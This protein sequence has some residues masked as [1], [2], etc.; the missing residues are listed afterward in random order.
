MRKL[1][2]LLAFVAVVTNANAQ[3]KVKVSGSKPKVGNLIHG[4][5]TD[6]IGPMES[7][8]IIE[9]DTINQKI[10][11]ETLT[12]KNG[13]FSIELVN[14]AHII[15]A[16]FVLRYYDVSSSIIGSKFEFFLRKVPESRRSINYLDDKYKD[17]PL[18][19]LDG[20]PTY[21]ES[22]DGIDKT[23]DSYSKKEVSD[24][25]GIPINTIDK[26]TVLRGEAAMKEWGTR[27]K[28]GVIQIQTIRNSESDKGKSNSFK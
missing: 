23:K 13:H 8:R 12:D 9:F 4:I 3:S 2:I 24:L 10:V 27:A 1:F 28:N 20:E 21:L 6:S 14:N 5:V 16:A 19:L 7:V 17:S 18:L 25:M 11:A 26:I 15:S 22:W